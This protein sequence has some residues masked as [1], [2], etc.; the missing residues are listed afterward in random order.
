MLG[1]KQVDLYVY[2]TPISKRTARFVVL[3]E[4]KSSFSLLK[5]Q[6]QEFHNIFL[7]K[8]GEPTKKI[9]E[10]WIAGYENY[11]SALK[12]GK[13]VYADYWFSVGTISI[14]LSVSKFLQLEISYENDKN[15]QLMGA[16]IKKQN[17]NIY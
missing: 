14:S 5:E 6:F 2:S 17:L 10:T 4:E 3:F 1:L 16:E 15:M 13:I 9:R 11:E 7:E 12:N 8:Y